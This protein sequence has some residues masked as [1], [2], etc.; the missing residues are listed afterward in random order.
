MTSTFAEIEALYTEKIAPHVGKIKAS[1]MIVDWSI[2]LAFL[3]GILSLFSL[4]FGWVDGVKII[5]EHRNE[6]MILMTFVVNFC[7]HHPLLFG[8]WAA[9]S[10]IIFRLDFSE[11]YRRFLPFYLWDNYFESN[12]QAFVIPPLLKK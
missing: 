3:Q 12:Y 7:L 9:I 10:V 2:K 8:C 11:L 1:M 6:L 4:Y 5:R